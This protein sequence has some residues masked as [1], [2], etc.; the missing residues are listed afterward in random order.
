VAVY[1]FSENCIATP[2]AAGSGL[3]VYHCQSGN[4]AFLSAES[5]FEN[6]TD[7]MTQKFF[8]ENEFH[9]AIN[10]TEIQSNHSLRWLL[11]NN[12]LVET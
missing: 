6:L 1:A 12:F 2:M 8:N 11:Q 9:H 3:A 10:G 7:L 4:S 5:T